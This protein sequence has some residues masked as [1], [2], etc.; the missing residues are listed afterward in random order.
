[1]RTLRGKVVKVSKE[2]VAN[3]AKM[4]SKDG[5]NFGSKARSINRFT[6]LAKSYNEECEGTSGASKEVDIDYNS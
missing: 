1:M 3:V 6:I 5:D 2:S 4:A